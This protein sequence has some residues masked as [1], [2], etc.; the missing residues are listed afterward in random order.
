ML[1]GRDDTALEQTAAVCRGQGVAIDVVGIDLTAP[2]AMT[3]LQQAW[4]DVPAH[5]VVWAA[6]AFDWASADV[7]DADTWDRLIDVNLAAA[8]R[9]TRL[10]L[11][12]LIAAGGGSLVF[13]ASLAGLD[14]FANN[15]AYV[16]SKHGLVAFSRAVFLD[17]RDRGVKVCAICPGLVD[18]GASRAFPAAQRV[19]FLQPDDVAD[20][21]LYAVTTSSCCVSNRDPSRTT[22]EPPRDVTPARRSRTMRVSSSLFRIRTAAHV[23]T[24]G[25]SRSSW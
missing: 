22:A 5:H 3:V 20:A 1:F 12:G 19:R 8:M 7:A 10:V 2:D 14:I 17:V 15:A 13:V 6:G 24:G 23:R 18:A 11:P 4:I 25:L 21:V 16:A 9:T